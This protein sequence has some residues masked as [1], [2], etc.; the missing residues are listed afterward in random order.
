M[1]ITLKPGVVIDVLTQ[2]EL[3]A[4]L[5]QVLSGFARGPATN[6]VVTSVLLNSGGESAI[7]STAGAVPV[8]KV[9]PGHRFTLHRASFRP[10]GYTFAVPY[11]SSTGYIEIQRAGT[12][13]DGIAFT[14]PG[15]PAI[16][17]SGSADGAIFDNGE[18]VDVL[19]VDG[20]AS[21]AVQIVLQGTMAPLTL[22]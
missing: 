17:T 19:I 1:K 7:G 11:T 15:L 9:P 14:T 20:P 8:W 4:T 10:D 6:R 13:V 22:T 2:D 16:L 18:T 3:A 21:K 5:T 12:L